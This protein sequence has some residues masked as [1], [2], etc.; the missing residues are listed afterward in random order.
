[1]EVEGIPLKQWPMRELRRRHAL[2]LVDHML[3]VQGRA[4]TGVVGIL[5]SLSAMAED[6][7]TDE[8]ADLN[9]FKG[10]RV[11]AS[12]PRAKKQRRPVRVFNFEQM[13]S[14]AK[15]AAPY[16]AMVRVFTDTGMRLGE[17]LPLRREDFD[18]ETLKVRRT[19]FEGTILAGTKTDHGEQA[20]GRTVPCPATLAWMIEAQIRLNG[21]D[22][23]L[24]FPTSTGRLWRQRNFYRDVWK[25]TQ[26]RSG[27]DIRPDECRHSYVT[28]LRAAGVNDADLAE[29]AGHRVETMLAR[30]THPVGWSFEAVRTAVG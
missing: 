19:A 28:H 4:T 21:E 8:V 12:D 22:C 18:G 15:A 13:H 5:R 29:I 24:L 3:R 17:V 11:R 25:P 20:A 16:E 26:E 1:V 9:P 6:A 23:E 30:Y 14:F 2:A 7:I 10:V 27:I